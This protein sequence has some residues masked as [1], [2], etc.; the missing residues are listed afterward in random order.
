MADTH[1]QIST[2]LLFVC[3]IVHAT[4]CFRT[5][6]N[7]LLSCF[8]AY[9]NMSYMLKQLLLFAATT[10][11]LSMPLQ[12]ICR[13]LRSHNDLCKFRGQSPHIFGMYAVLQ[14]PCYKMKS[15]LRTFGL[16]KR[17]ICYF[18]LHDS[19]LEMCGPLADTFKSVLL[20][21]PKVHIPEISFPVSNLGSALFLSKNDIS[22]QDSSVILL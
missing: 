20:H 11:Q 21:F 15:G 12:L 18:C 9:G 7:L 8:H 14:C 6:P 5:T 17:E 16:L 10:K 2:L 22:S 1:V 3:A 19:K 13:S 4:L